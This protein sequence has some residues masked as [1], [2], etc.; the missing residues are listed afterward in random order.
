MHDERTDPSMY[1][2]TEAWFVSHRVYPERT[3]TFVF[4]IVFAFDLAHEQPKST[5]VHVR[6]RAEVKY[7]PPT[8]H[9]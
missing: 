5:Y 1:H 7:D 8:F 6:Q 2:S 3:K 9:S 4:G